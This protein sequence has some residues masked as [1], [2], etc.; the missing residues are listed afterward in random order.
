MHPYFFFFFVFLVYKIDMYKNLLKLLLLLSSFPLV[1][2]PVAVVVTVVSTVACGVEKD[3]SS[4]RNRCKQQ[5]RKFSSS[6]DKS[7]NIDM[8]GLCTPDFG[9]WITAEIAAK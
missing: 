2:R 7:D 8:R 1:A 5:R 3:V 6:P 9:L 4:A